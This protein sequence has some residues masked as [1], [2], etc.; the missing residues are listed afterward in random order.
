MKKAYQPETLYKRY[1]YQIEN[2]LA[3]P[4]PK[5][6]QQGAALANEYP[7]RLTMLIKIFWMLGVRA[8]YRRIFWKYTWPWL[9]H[10]KIEFL[11]ATS[12]C[13]HHLISFARDAYAGRTN[14]S[15]YAHGQRDFADEAA[16]Q[17]TA[18]E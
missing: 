11:I 7:P 9:K 18:A 12:V 3:E 8:D 1:Q 17:V 15:N 10:G 16:P 4:H 6:S 2:T 14:A 13:A 5:P